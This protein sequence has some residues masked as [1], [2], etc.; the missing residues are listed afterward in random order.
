MEEWTGFSSRDFAVFAETGMQA[1]GLAS[2][3]SPGWLSMISHDN[4]VA[5]DSLTFA[6]PRGERTNSTAVAHDLELMFLEGGQNCRFR[7]KTSDALRGRGMRTIR[8]GF[9]TRPGQG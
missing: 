5:G 6:L 4:R 1:Q 7:E 9:S 8:T 3:T 2:G